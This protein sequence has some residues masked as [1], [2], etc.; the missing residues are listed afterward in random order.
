MVDGVIL[1]AN[2]DDCEEIMEMIKS[3]ARYERMES[4][5]SIDSNRLKTDLAKKKFECL[6]CKN[7]ACVLVGFA[8]FVNTYDIKEGKK[9]YLEDLFVKEDYRKQGYGSKL[10][11]ELASKCKENNCSYLEFSVLKWNKSAIQFYNRQ[12]CKNSTELDNKQ[13]FRYAMERMSK[14][15]PGFGNGK[16]VQANKVKKQLENVWYSW[17][18]FTDTIHQVLKSECRNKQEDLTGYCS[19]ISHLFEFV[20]IKLFIISALPLLIYLT[21]FKSYLF[22]KEVLDLP[23]EPHTILPI[24]E[25]SMFQCLPHQILSRRWNIT[26]D[27]LAAVPYL[28]HFV[29]P[30][31][32][33]AY[34]IV[35]RRG[36]GVPLIY[37][38]LW[39]VG[40]VNIV[41]GRHDLLVLCWFTVLANIYLYLIAVL[42]YF[43]KCRFKC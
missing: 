19:H 13:V 41:A 26:F 15:A 16:T 22:L 31:L 17:N 3:L 43:Y 33:I 6:V 36:G 25:Y 21:I 27:L 23:E 8:L 37:Q 18:R 42:F 39:C 38:Y 34:N 2:S 35:T 32:F 24:I 4:S 14:N 30:V 9:M 20:N 40:W 5:V 1:P 28:I 7:Q 29:L 11:N 12:G 10:W